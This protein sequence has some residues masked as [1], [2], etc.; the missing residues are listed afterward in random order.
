MRP[1]PPTLRWPLLAIAAF[2][3]LGAIPAGVG[4]V[5]RPDGS[6][7]GMPLT[8][9]A[10]TPFPDFRL[11][12]LILT[13]VVGGATLAAAVLV[14]VGSPRAADVALAAGA[15]VVGW[16]AGQLALIAYV[17]PLQ[18]L[19]AGLGLAMIGLAWKARA[20]A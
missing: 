2:L 7:V 12:G 13:L 10:G 11:P 3:A 16:I 1:L 8:V 20:V 15:V 9:L 6:L 5:L 18:P 4:F 17:S 14:A 19:V